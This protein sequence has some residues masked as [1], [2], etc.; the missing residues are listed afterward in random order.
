MS[1]KK[2]RIERKARKFILSESLEYSAEFKHSY[3]FIESLDNRVNPVIR[4]V[5]YID[6]IRT[7]AQE[8]L[9]KQDNKLVF[10]ALLQLKRHSLSEREQ[11]DIK[12]I[13]DPQDWRTNIYCEYLLQSIIAN[14]LYKQMIRAQI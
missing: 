11:R 6:L 3:F 14:S 1:P 9:E 4:T 8:F 13:L 2:E 7:I 5:Y 10:I 12:V